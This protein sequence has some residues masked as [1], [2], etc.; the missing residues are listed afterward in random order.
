ML[1]SLTQALLGEG[2]YEQSSLSPLRLR[3]CR[4]LP[5]LQLR[6]PWM[7]RLAHRGKLAPRIG[8]TLKQ[9]AARRS[10]SMS[11]FAR[12]VLEQGGPECAAEIL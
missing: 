11:C 9:G 5:L 10:A 3:G 7:L 6:A 1:I 12:C 2:V 8:Y 4:A